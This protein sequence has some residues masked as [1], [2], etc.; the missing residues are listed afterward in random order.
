MRAITR[1]AAKIA[2][3]TGQKTDQK[4]GETDETNGTDVTM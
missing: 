4:V 2:A 1:I 3:K